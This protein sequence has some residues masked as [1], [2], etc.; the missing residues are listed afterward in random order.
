MP[1]CAFDIITVLILTVW[2][3]CSFY[4]EFSGLF[5]LAYRKSR[6]LKCLASDNDWNLFGSRNW[7]Y[8]IS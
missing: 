7:Y 8:F 2:S 3:K 4:T 1:A 6:R 5:M